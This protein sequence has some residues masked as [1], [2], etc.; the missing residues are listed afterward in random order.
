LTNVNPEAEFIEEADAM[1]SG[2]APA[3]GVSECLSLH[4]AARGCF[5]NGP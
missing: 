3:G 1:S 4:G 2:K 5:D